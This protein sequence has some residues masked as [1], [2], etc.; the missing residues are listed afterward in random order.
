[1]A[2]DDLQAGSFSTWATPLREEDKAEE[3]LDF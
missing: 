3:C 2:Q 1:M